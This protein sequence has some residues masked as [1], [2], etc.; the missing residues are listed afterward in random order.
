MQISYKATS[1]AQLLF[2]VSAIPFTV[3]AASAVIITVILSCM[4]LPLKSNSNKIIF[5]AIN[6][7]NILL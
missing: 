3:T 1:S 7:P 5:L 2:T 4:I 6:S